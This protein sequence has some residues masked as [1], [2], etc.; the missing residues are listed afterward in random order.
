MELGQQGGGMAAAEGLP[1][2]EKAHDA[3][4]GRRD[5]SCSLHA[6]SSYLQQGSLT[7]PV[8]GAVLARTARAAGLVGGRSPLPRPARLIS[9]T[10]R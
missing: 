9:L 4:L 8:D 10:L 6:V 2:W 7:G 1:Q 5:N 3:N